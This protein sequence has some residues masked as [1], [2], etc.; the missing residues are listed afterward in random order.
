MPHFQ[1]RVSSLFRSFIP[2]APAAVCEQSHP[3]ARMLNAHNWPGIDNTTAIEL[4]FGILIFE[5]YIELY[6]ALDSKQ[7]L[8]LEP[9]YQNFIRRMNVGTSRSLSSSPGDAVKGLT[10]V[11]ATGSSIIAGVRALLPKSEA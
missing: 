6:R 10:S 5:N 2:H 9:F 8:V 11:W 7:V 3:L 4:L 1:Q